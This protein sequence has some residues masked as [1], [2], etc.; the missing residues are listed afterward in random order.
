MYQN[1]NLNQNLNQKTL[2]MMET[3]TTQV[4]QL[5]EQAKEEIQTSMVANNINASGRTS[6]SFRV[7]DS[8]DG[9]IRLLMGGEGTAPLATL[10]IGRE[11]GKVPYGFTDILFEWSQNKGISF[12]DDRERRT[13]AWFLGKRIAREGTLRHQTPVDVYSSIV[14]DAV[15]RLKV[16][17]VKA[18]KDNFPEK[19]LP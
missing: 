9:H 7:E 16:G 8:G 3:L 15:A 19:R 14:Q 13:F 12:P 18:V 1:L 10:E 6:D 2:T 5:L 4:I 17:I 11:G